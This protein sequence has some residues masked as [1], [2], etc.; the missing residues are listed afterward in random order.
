MRNA[1]ENIIMRGSNL[2]HSSTSFF[3]ATNYQNRVETQSRA[4]KFRKEKQ[5]FDD[6]EILLKKHNIMLNTAKD[7][8]LTKFL[9]NFDNLEDGAIILSLLQ[10]W[11][12]HPSKES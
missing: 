11:K 6:L 2:T 3:E 10:S 12:G 8:I 5:F 1:N 9:S 4:T 7:K